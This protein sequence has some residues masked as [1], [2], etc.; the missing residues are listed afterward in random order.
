MKTVKRYSSQEV[1]ASRLRSAVERETPDL[2]NRIM[3]A[4]VNHEAGKEPAERKPH[5]SVLKYAVSFTLAAAVLGGAIFVPKLAVP[6]EQQAGKKPEFGIAASSRHKATMAQENPFALKAYAAEAGSASQADKGFGLSLGRN[7]SVSGIDCSNRS[8]GRIYENQ[9][10]LKDDGKTLLYANYQGFNL[11]C[12]GNHIK[13]VTY[14]TS[15]GGFAQVKNLPLKEFLRISNSIPWAVEQRR[16][17]YADPNYRKNILKKAPNEKFDLPEPNTSYGDG[18]TMEVASCGWGK[19]KNQMEYNGYLPVGASYTMNYKDQD[20]YTKQYVVRVL[21]SISHK[22]A[23]ANIKATYHSA[24]KQ[25]E[26]TT[27]TVTAAYEDGSTA[28]KQCV[29]H[30]DADTWELRAV[31]K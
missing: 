1:I 18:K 24:L 21:S 12:V 6:A 20:D 15:Q 7:I 28:S 23:D 19:N 17:Q 27:I 25:M 26:G 13:S 29:L 22:D 10:L 9:S 3:S 5:R 16:E 8:A 30:L 4:A 2:K 31:E 11:R 14:T